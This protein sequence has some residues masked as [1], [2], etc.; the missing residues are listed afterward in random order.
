[1]KEYGP[2]VLRLGIGGLFVAA[3]IMKLFDPAMIEGMLG[4]FGFPAPVFWTWLLILSE[5]FFGTAVLTGFKLKWTTIPL[6]I[7][8]VV[9]IVLSFDNI[10][11]V[12]NNIVFLFCLL[13][14]WLSG[15]GALA[16]HHKA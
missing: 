12:M 7:I 6:A 11:V 8:L 1:M 5:L 10:G 15:P 2:F 14:L 9:A 13:S 4:G 3:G 16:L